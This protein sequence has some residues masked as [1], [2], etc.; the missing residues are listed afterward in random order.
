ML[1]L[2][3]GADRAS[4]LLS[5]NGSPAGGYFWLDKDERDAALAA[6]KGVPLPSNALL[7]ENETSPERRALLEKYVALAE[8]AAQREGALAATD[9]RLAL[10]EKSLA[11]IP[12]WLGGAPNPEAEAEIRPGKE[13]KRSPD[14]LLKLDSAYVQLLPGLHLDRAKQRRAL[15]DTQLRLAK[16]ERALEEYDLKEGG[17]IVVVPYAGAEKTA[18]RLRYGY[19][20]PASCSLSYRLAAQPDKDSV[21]IAQ[22]VAL[23]QTSGFAWNKVDTFV[24]TLRR[25]GMLKP[26]LIRPWEILLRPVHMFKG[27]AREEMPMAMAPAP[28]QA[29]VNQRVKK[30][31]LML[32][33]EAAVPPFEPQQEERSTFR[34]WSLGKQRIEHKTPVRLPLATDTYPAKY[35]YT[36]RPVSNP[37]G[38]LTAELSLPAAIEL[39]PGPAQFSVDGVAVGQQGF[40]FNGDKGVIFFG[41]DPQI[42]ATVRNL[43]RSSGEQGL[44]SKEQTLS[45]HWQI[46]LKSARSKPVSVLLEDPAPDTS[47]ERIAITAESSPK[48]E[49]VVNPSEYGGAK[50]YRW[51]AS[52][53]PGETLIIDHKVQAVAPKTDGYEL[54]PGRSINR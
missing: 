1:S 24:S 11:G 54:D 14:E 47:D 32:V 3:P 5:I 22:D 26:E 49:L 2:P 7:P 37:K 15:E 52:L 40:S 10:W 25:D 53:K 48:P 18:L 8:E 39:P 29:A 30:G 4:F 9:A 46:S 45:W 13:K 31:S 19:V 33:E 36:L 20:L 41:S 21:S 51:K 43:K 50:V 34:L 35:H 44:I 17:E 16:A 27:D 28:Q 42:T 6:R 38:F 12:Q 23:S